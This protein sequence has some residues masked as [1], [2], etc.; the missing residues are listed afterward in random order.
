MKL[1][2]ICIQS[3]VFALLWIGFIPHSYA[4]LSSY[5][6]SGKKTFRTAIYYGKMSNQWSQKVEDVSYGTVVVD[7]GNTR[8]T[9]APFSFQSSHRYKIIGDIIALLYT[10][11]GLSDK[12]EPGTPIITSVIGWHNYALSLYSKKYLQLSLGGHIGDYYYGIEG[13]S[14]ANRK[15]PDNTSGTMYYYGGGGPL[16]IAD[17]A[18]FNSG[19]IFHYEGAYAFTFGEKPVA[20]DVK[21][22]ILNQTFELRLEKLYVCFELVKGLNTTGNRIER[23]QI[24]L[25]FSM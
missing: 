1:K 19:I 12:P 18:L 22:N 20:P 6:L 14:T 9:Y 21:P 5:S 2:N 7:I 3:I 17:L 8:S 13:L 16:L 15:S 25:G 10:P 23:Y 11:P 24:G 4:Q